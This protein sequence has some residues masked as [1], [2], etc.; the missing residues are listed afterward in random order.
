MRGEPAHDTNRKSV[1]FMP[2]QTLSNAGDGP[3]EPRPSGG[4]IV[5][6]VLSCFVRCCVFVVRFTVRHALGVWRDVEEAPPTPAALSTT[7]I[8]AAHLHFVIYVYYKYQ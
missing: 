1:L 6:G 5:W 8:F 2:A 3:A 7:V 4:R